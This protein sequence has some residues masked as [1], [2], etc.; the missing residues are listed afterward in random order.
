MKVVLLLELGL[1]LGS[2]L[3]LLVPLLCIGVLSERLLAAVG[4][5]KGY[6][7]A[8][9]PAQSEKN[10]RTEPT[11]PP[12]CKDLPRKIWTNRPIEPNPPPQRT[13]QRKTAEKGRTEPNLPNR[14]SEPNLLDRTSA[15]NQKEG[16]PNRI[17]NLGSVQVHQGYFL[18]VMTN[19]VLC[20]CV[21]ICI[22]ARELIV[23]PRCGL[24][25]SNLFVHCFLKISFLQQ[26]E[27]NWK[28]LVWPPESY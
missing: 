17:P 4:W 22:Y 1:L 23:C 7:K 26:P 5:H 25:E 20:V 14:T 12:H 21:Y 11:P 16:K 3:P 27:A 8:R 13:S 6:L 28:L 9:Q 2:A 24:F 19:K 15:Y 10:D 18:Q